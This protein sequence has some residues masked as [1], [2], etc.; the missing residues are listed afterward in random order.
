M[1][2]RRELRNFYFQCLNPLFFVKVLVFLFF[3]VI[4]RPKWWFKPYRL[5]PKQVK[6]AYCSCKNDFQNL[7]KLGILN[8]V[9]KYKIDCGRLSLSAGYLNYT[10]ESVWSTEFQDQ[11]DMFSLHRWNWLLTALTKNSKEHNEEW[12]FSLMRSWIN[13]MMDPME[14]LPWAPY[15]TGERISNACLFAVLAKTNNN[16][17]PASILPNDIIKALGIMAFYLLDNLEFKGKYR[18]G[19]HV[20]NNARALLFAGVFLNLECLIDLSSSILKEKLPGL[21]TKDGFLREGSSHYQFLFTR[22]ILEML[23]LSRISNN[24]TIQ[25]FITPFTSKLVKQCWFF[26]VKDS[27]SREWSIPLIGDISPDFPPEWLIYLPWSNLALNVYCP[28]VIP[29]LPSGLSGWASLV[30]NKQELFN[31][32]K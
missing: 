17:R 32:S 12:G 23:W 31:V 3:K 4:N 22:W 7:S 29:P 28:E 25:K 13:R 14:G 19:N 20:I 16:F 2:S 30:N 18:T 9:E 24:D 27:Y 26:L 21:V 11:E 8:N 5:Y 15:T 6:K 1:I 10:D